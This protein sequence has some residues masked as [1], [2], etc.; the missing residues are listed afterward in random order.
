MPDNPPP[1]GDAAAPGRA[2]A[3][4]SGAVPKPNKKLRRESE[5]LDKSKL[6]METTCDKLDAACEKLAAQKPPKKPGIIK[7]AGR[8]I[9]AEAWMAAHGKI[10]QAE[11]ENVGIKAAHRTELAGEGAVRGASRFIKRRIRTRPARRVRKLEKREIKAR[12]DYAFRKAA[13]ENPELKS[14]PFSRY[15]QKRRLRSQFRKEAR[16]AARATGTVGKR[17]AAALKRA[18]RKLIRAA[19]AGPKMVLILILCLLLI[20]MIQSCVGGAMTIGHGLLGA[21][22]GTSFLAEDSDMNAAGIAYSEWETDL[23]LEALNAETSHPGFDEYRFEI[24]E[25]GHD[26][27]ALM[28]FLTAMFDDFTFAEVEPVLRDIFNQQYTLTFTGIVEVRSRI[29]TWTDGDGNDHSEVVYYNFYILEVVLTARPFAE[30]IGS[31]LTTQEARDRYDVYNLIRGNRQYVGS[32]F[33]FNW[34]PHVSSLFGYRQCPFT[35]AK[36]FHTGLDIAL[37][38]GTEILA[39]GSGVVLSAGWA[40]DYGLAVV[41]DYGN[42]ITARYAHCS[43]LLVSAGQ[44]VEAGDVIALVGST[45]RSTG[46]HLHAEVMLNG[47]FMNP[48]FFM[49]IP[50]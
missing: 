50:N 27:I 11:H 10:Y 39:G 1:A 19:L 30:V 48:L 29:E 23:L 2:A 26:P 42:G 35:G 28:A 32:P 46:A 49:V 9:K 22:G 17:I 44:T 6:R 43:V 16:Q 37:P 36:E 21:V 41:I 34:L 33:P 38:E 31:M 3:A 13:R 5:K 15:M 24:D 20:V 14:N 47:E 40:G 25:M 12:A 18:G 45:G 7:S 8:F 4:G